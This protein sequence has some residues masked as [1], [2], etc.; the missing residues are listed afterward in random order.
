ML[1]LASRRFHG[2]QADKAILSRLRNGAL[3]DPT[4]IR[5]LQMVSG[6]APA[7]DP[8]EQIVYNEV[9]PHGMGRTYWY[10]W[11]GGQGRYERGGGTDE[12]EIKRDLN[13]GPAGF[14]E[15]RQILRSLE[16]RRTIH[17]EISTTDQRMGMLTFA[18][19]TQHI[20]VHVDFGCGPAPGED[21]LDL[22]NAANQIVLGW[23]GKQ[24]AL[25]GPE[26]SRNCGACAP[27]PRN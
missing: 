19:G 22:L 16:T 26:A 5:P 24:R 10:L 13:V 11:A 2:S 25:D 23:A 3:T 18:R 17:C 21:A 27:L 20:T 15:I 6:K 1:I 12:V 9:G 14:R 7:D 8:P 4:C